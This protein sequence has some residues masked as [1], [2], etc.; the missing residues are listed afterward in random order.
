MAIIDTI[1]LSTFRDY[2]TQSQHINNFSYMTD[3]RVNNGG[4]M[5]GY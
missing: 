1:N 2:F 5:G 4:R 3:H